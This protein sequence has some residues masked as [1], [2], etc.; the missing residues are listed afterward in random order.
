M[1]GEQVVRS[2]DIIGKKVKC[3]HQTRIP[4]RYDEE[5]D[6]ECD[7][8]WAVESI[9][10][11]GGGVLI[12]EPVET[13]GNPV[14]KAWYRRSSLTRDQMMKEILP[15]LNKLFGLPYEDQEEPDQMPEFEEKVQ[16]RK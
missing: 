8:I 10:F 12:L 9:E 1:K 14:V 4:T 13:D 11:E 7:F 6:R 2:A 16:L 5:K 15:G 3:V